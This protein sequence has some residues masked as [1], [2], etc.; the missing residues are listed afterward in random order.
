VSAHAS[1]G[2]D[3][4]PCLLEARGLSS[5]YQ[6]LPVV[7]EVDL[8]VHAG[9]VVALLGPNGAGKTTTLLALA[10]ALPALQGEVMM[11]GG[12]ARGPMHKRAR[13]GLALVPGDRSVFTGLTV[14]QNLAV[15]TAPED[16]VCSLFPELSP[17]LNRAGGKLSGGEQQMVVLGR[18][19]ARHPKVVL[20]DEVSLGLAPQVV[21][22]L[23]QALRSAAVER[24]IG[25]VI[26]EQHI[27]QALKWADRVYTMR[28]GRILHSGT[29]EE[30]RKDVEK[31]YF[32]DE[33]V[34]PRAGRSD[35]GRP[36]DG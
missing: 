2:A 12:P 36:A 20:A 9:E 32:Q 14:A 35:A 8:R 15:A 16:E 4:R 27:H 7:H 18:A 5:G 19:L 21:T 10:G 11:D 13:Q 29:V 6:G 34:E 22:R 17:L 26:V 24:Q 30:V 25:V 3:A 31:A 23:L 28:R 33:D 1:N